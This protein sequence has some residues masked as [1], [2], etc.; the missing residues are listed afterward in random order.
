MLLLGPSGAGK[1]TL[2]AAIGGLLAPD[3]GEQAGEILIDGAPARSARAGIGVVFQDPETQIIMARCG[4]DVAFGLESAGV[5][6]GAITPRVRA[7]LATVGF[8]H[9][10]DHDTAALSGGEKQRLALA[11]ALAP[12]PGL[13]LLD[14]PTANLDPVGAALVR[15][16]LA[17]I[18]GRTMI[19]VEHR[20]AEVL[21]LVDRVVVLADGAGVALD[22]TPEKVFESH[23]ADLAA[24]GVWVPDLALSPRLSA[25]AP[26]AALL[27]GAGLSYRHRGAVHDAL[28]AVDVTVHE[29]QAL[30]VLGRNGAGKST[31]ARILGGLTKPSTGTLAAPGFDGPPW[32]WRAAALATRIGSVFQEPEHQFVT[33]RVRDEL[34]FGGVPASTVDDLLG[35]LRLAP[36]A[37]ANPYTLS[38]GQQRRLSVATALAKAPRTLVLDEPTFGQDLRTWRELVDII[39]DLRDDGHGVVLVTHDPDLV[40]TLADVRLEL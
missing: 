7:A 4:D 38:G 26:G 25:G 20:V 2:L 21:P 8:D 19:L 23:A 30:A 36:L 17:R 15:E 1:S 3:T 16:A 22:G 31:L 37:M 35:R 33:Q 34:A 10:L 32:R 28:S 5:P 18:T 27:V 6:A 14:E 9:S 24:Q 13:L 11:G 39:A 29:G 12:E 40:E